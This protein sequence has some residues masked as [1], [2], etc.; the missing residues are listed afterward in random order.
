MATVIALVSE[1]PEP[2]HGEKACILRMSFEAGKGY[3]VSAV[4]VPGDRAIGRWISDCPLS[5]AQSALLWV[6]KE[7]WVVQQSE[8][9]LDMNAVLDQVARPT[10]M[11]TPGHHPLD[12]IELLCGNFPPRHPTNPATGATIML[13]PEPQR[14]LGG[15]PGI[16]PRVVHVP[17][18]PAPVP[19]PARGPAVFA[20]PVAEA[21]QV[22]DPRRELAVFLRDSIRALKDGHDPE[23]IRAAVVQSLGY[24]VDEGD[25]EDDEELDDDF[26]DEIEEEEGEISDADLDALLAEHNISVLDPIPAVPP[27]SA[28][29]ILPPVP[30]GLR[31]LM[32]GEALPPELESHLANIGDDGAARAKLERTA[33]RQARQHESIRRNM[34]AAGVDT[35]LSVAEQLAAQEARY[36]KLRAER[37]EP[38]PIPTHPANRAAIAAMAEGSEETVPA[39]SNGVNGQNGT[40][41]AYLSPDEISAL[42]ASRAEEERQ[43]RIA[44]D[45]AVEPEVSLSPGGEH[46]EAAG[47]SEAVSESEVVPKPT[48]SIRIGPRQS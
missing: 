32:P 4:A 37:G 18:A 20:P 19:T 25:F 34:A 31:P 14:A 40:A 13:R 48:G 47:E 41:P 16:P 17:P 39:K 24:S 30:D 28:V 1:M 42:L 11:H 46:S 44:S 21:P 36:A 5:V 2:Q 26:G 29:A 3:R 22:S 6:S 12:V 27:Q 15:P 8:D 38:D 33:E 45:V 10:P 7:Q 9:S 43:A 35:S 23:I